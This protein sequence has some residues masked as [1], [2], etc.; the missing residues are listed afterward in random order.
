MTRKYVWRL[1]VRIYELNALG[2][3]NNTMYARYLEEAAVRASADAGYG[4]T[5]YA[6]NGTIWVIRK[7]YLRYDAP[8][9]YGDELEITT[10]VADFRRV[11]SHREYEVRRVRDGR[12]VLRGRA[13]WVYVDRE[14][15]RPLRIPLA[16]MR[17]FGSAGELPDIGTRIHRARRIDGAY[18]YRQ[19][20]KVQR[21][22]LD[23]VGHVNHAV[24]LD[25]IEQAVLEA[26][27]SVGYTE[28]RMREEAFL[29][30]AG[31][32]EAEYLRGATDGDP[33]EIVSVPYELGGV[34]GAWR[35]EVRHGETGELLARDY[36]VGVFAGLDGRPIRAAS[37]LIEK[38]VAGPGRWRMQ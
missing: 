12:M 21:Y 11:Q 32:H 8:A 27:A 19:Q 14:T 18:R 28:A 20:R 3:V 31:A 5:W 37:G 33:I 10:W 34:R 16:M 24:Y 38:V 2:R 22:E 6:E 23:S 17:D 13:N 7:L 35:H 15:L 26:M 29:I 1:Q 4:Y 9:V 25:W 36:N 30:L